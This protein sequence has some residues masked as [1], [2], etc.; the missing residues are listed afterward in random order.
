MT[1]R[2]T[3]PLSG[4]ALSGTGTDP[5]RLLF[6]VARRNGWKEALDTL[7]TRAGPGVL[8]LGPGGHAIA[9]AEAAATAVRV[10][11]GGLEWPRARGTESVYAPPVPGLV[12]IRSKLEP[13][14]EGTAVWPAAW[15]TT[16]AGLRL[17]LSYGLLDAAV[18]HLGARLAGDASLLQ[19]Q[20]IKGTIADVTVDHL[21]IRAVLETAGTEG[22]P[23]DSVV[24]LHGR[25]T[26]ADRTTLRLFG[27]SGYVE[28]GAG[29]TAHLSELL[30]DVYVGPANGE[31]TV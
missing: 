13:L 15:A 4:P 19:H 2:S 1:V 7:H 6:D 5:W 16:L 22:L 21:E 8:L 29:R 23:W 9:S 26:A 25:T 30:A 3:P 18:S 17:G 24:D 31:V 27:A 12:A 10:R 14:S 11:L 28:G 20:M